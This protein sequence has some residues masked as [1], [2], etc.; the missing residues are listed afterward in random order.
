M[1]CLPIL[2]HLQHSPSCLYHSSPYH[3]GGCTKVLHA[4]VQNEAVS[5]VPGIVH[6]CAAPWQAHDTSTKTSRPHCQTLCDPIHHHTYYEVH[7]FAGFAL[8]DVLRLQIP[9][10]QA[11]FMNVLEQPCQLC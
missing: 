11:T 5:V 4:K 1:I 9:M 3:P 10:H 7:Y 6:W 2:F 8:H